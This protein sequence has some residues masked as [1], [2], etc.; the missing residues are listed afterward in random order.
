MCQYVVIGKSEA[1]RS[2]GLCRSF[3]GV[4]RSQLYRLMPNCK[5]V[6]VNLASITIVQLPRSLQKK[7]QFFFK[8]PA[9]HQCKNWLFLGSPKGDQTAVFRFTF[10][11]GCT[12]Q[13]VETW[14]CLR[15]VLQSLAL[16]TTSDELCQLFLHQWK[17]IPYQSYGI[18]RTDTK[19]ARV[20]SIFIPSADSTLRNFASVVHI[21]K[22]L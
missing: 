10:Q 11:A 9:G 6:A 7:I 15:E 18:G 13:E 19:H 17:P 21:I 16:P 3:V 1:G 4:S 20:I 2:A 5:L 14:V 12:H 8:C 22:V